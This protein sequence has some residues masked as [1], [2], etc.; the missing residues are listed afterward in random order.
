MFD[1]KLPI[2]LR[3]FVVVMPILVGLLGGSDLSARAQATPTAAT[4]DVPSPQ[5]CLVAPRPLPLFPAEVGQRAAATPG[6]LPTAPAQPFVP[7]TG[8]A[9]D[10]ET[11]KGVTATVREALACRNGNDLLRAYALFTEDMIVSL[12][13]GP[14][15]IDPEV[16]QAVVEQ[17]SPLPRRQRLAL[18]SLT[19]VVL[20]P[21][22]RAGAIVETQAGNQTFRDYLVFKHDSTSGRWLID[23]TKVIG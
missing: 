12:F 9:A 5:E 14:A 6:P 23:G 7:P 10:A 20:L 17:P 4:L 1:A 15:T 16:Q 18:V 22:G 2:E 3:W 19:D 13:G 8:E 11:I 21:D